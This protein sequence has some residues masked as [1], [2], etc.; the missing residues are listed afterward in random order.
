M[1]AAA[2]GEVKES[3]GA[4]DGKQQTLMKYHSEFPRHTAFGSELKRW[5]MRKK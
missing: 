1:L 4:V 3:L 5:G 2:L